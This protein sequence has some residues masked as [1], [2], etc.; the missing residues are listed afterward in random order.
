MSSQ[1]R[2]DSIMYHIRH[3]IDEP[4]DFVDKDVD[5]PYFVYTQARAVERALIDA[6]VLDE[7]EG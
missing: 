4:F 6:G 2:R 5:D 1:L 7:V 3:A